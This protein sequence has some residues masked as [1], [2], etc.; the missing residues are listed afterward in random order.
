MDD[1]RRVGCGERPGDLCRLSEGLLD[2]ETARREHVVERFAFDAL[3]GDEVHGLALAE[4]SAVDVVD[5]DDVWMVER[6]GGLRLTDES[7]LALGVADGL[8][9]QEFQGDLPV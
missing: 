8:V 9:R 6:R 5:R 4:R 7:P 2:R 1:S 3:H